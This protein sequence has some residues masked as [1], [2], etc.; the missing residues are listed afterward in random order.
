MREHW[1][2][3]GLGPSDLGF[4][5]PVKT[6]VSEP[7]LLGFNS[8]SGQVEAVGNLSRLHISHAFC[9]ASPWD[10]HFSS[11]DAALCVEVINK[12]MMFS[13]RCAFHRSFYQH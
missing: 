10:K 2:I 5:V 12:E 6:N 13:V 11:C 7:L 1:I 9:N 8:T 3:L 4:Q